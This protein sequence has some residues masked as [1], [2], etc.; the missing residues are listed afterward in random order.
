MQID[1]ILFRLHASHRLVQ[2]FPN[3]FLDNILAFAK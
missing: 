2:L 3:C 1:L